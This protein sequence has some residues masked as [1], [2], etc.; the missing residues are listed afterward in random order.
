MNFVVS[1]TYSRN[2]KQQQISW[3]PKNQLIN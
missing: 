2:N 3:A 1:S